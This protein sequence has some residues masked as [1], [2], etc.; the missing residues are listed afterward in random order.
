MPLINEQN[1]NGFGDLGVADFIINGQA[2]S[3]NVSGA[4]QDAILMRTTAA[5]STV[6]LQLADPTRYLLRSGILVAGQILSLDGLSFT[7]VQ[8]TKASDTL[9]VVFEASGVAAL[10]LQTGVTV[11]TDNVTDITTFAAG[12]VAAVPGLNFVG[13]YNPAPQPVSVGRGSDT[14]PTED[15][16]TCLQRIAS[17]AGWRCF[18]V[19]NTVYYCS[20]QFLLNNPSSGVLQELTPQIQ[21][22]DFDYDVGKPFGNITA[23][24]MTQL[25]DFPPGN[26]AS[27]SGMGPCDGQ[28]WI[29]QD[30]QRSLLT[31]QCT[32]T[33]Y[34][35]MLPFDVINGTNT[36]TQF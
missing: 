2:L 5:A 8:V 18:E 32:I 22:M 6:N 20:D 33:L 26:I 25:W 17:S 21:N 29:I 13:E 4:V 34:Q 27:T 30:C 24:G 31:P 28:P 19:N 14:D 1:M 35:P 10:R 23:T 12:L 9:Q 15:S 7:L 36:T 3:A 11:S 16:W